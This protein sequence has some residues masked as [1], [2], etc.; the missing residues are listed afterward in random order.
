M[1]SATRSLGL[2]PAPFRNSALAK[3]SQPVAA[4]SACSLMSGV[5]P[6]RPATPSRMGS[7]VVD[8]DADAVAVA[9]DADL[10]RSS[11]WT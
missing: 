10:V 5:F 3:I 7:G 6:I 8:A 9:A 11:N 2:L 1:E 4:L